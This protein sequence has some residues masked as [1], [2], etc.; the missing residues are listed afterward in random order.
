MRICSSHGDGETVIASVQHPGMGLSFAGLTLLQ[1]PLLMVCNQAVVSRDHSLD[2]HTLR[3]RTGNSQKTRLANRRC[4]G[5]RS[6]AGGDSVR[7]L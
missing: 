5:A 7:V 2:R 6:V 4:D 1:S 3:R